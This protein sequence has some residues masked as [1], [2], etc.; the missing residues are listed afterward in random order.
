LVAPLVSFV[1]RD[2]QSFLELTGHSVRMFAAISKYAGLTMFNTFEK[3]M[4]YALNKI[5]LH[6]THIFVT[7][8]VENVDSTSE[9]ALI[10]G[11][12]RV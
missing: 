1:I 11:D 9:L 8:L 10:D 4:S 5:G 6:G 12:I 7:D 2:K 3:L